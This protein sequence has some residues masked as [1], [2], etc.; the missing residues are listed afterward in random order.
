MDIKFTGFGQIEINGQS[1]DYDV[2][3]DKGEVSKRKKKPSKAYR[4]QYGHTP[5]S[6]AENIPWGGKSLI[7]GTGAYGKLPIMPE[8]NNEADQRSIEI[9][10]VPTKEACRLVAETDARKVRAIL[11]VT[12]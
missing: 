11:H 7:I 10:A 2:I 3:I 9:I 1:Y 5:L 8:V 4:E 12:C 6:A